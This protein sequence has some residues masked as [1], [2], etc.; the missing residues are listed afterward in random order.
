MAT[1]R[2]RSG[3]AVTL[4]A[5]RDPLLLGTAAATLD[6]L[7]SGRLRRSAPNF[8][9]RLLEA[10]APERMLGIEPPTLGVAELDLLWDGST[11]L[12]SASPSTVDH[13]S[14]ER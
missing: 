9:S 8:S 6:Y 2:V 14:P 11:H 12:W 13:R 10:V 4:G 7:S 3:G 5:F 1:G